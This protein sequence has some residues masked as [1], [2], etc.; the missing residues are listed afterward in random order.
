M[1]LHKLSLVGGKKVK[2]SNPLPDLN[3]QLAKFRNKEEDHVPIIASTMIL[4]TG[5]SFGL[6]PLGDLLSIVI[7]LKE[8]YNLTCKPRLD[9]GNDVNRYECNC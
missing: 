6:L 7:K 3:P 5:M 4:D 2:P 9:Q 1:H 8:N